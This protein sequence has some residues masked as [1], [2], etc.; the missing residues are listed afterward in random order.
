[1]RIRGAIERSIF[2][3]GRISFPTHYIPPPRGTYLFLRTKWRAAA[4]VSARGS[5]RFFAI[6]AAGFASMA[7]LEIPSPAISVAPIRNLNGYAGPLWD[8]AWHRGCFTLSMDKRV[9]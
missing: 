9:R 6:E 7:P 3:S 2:A 8:S 1:M 4:D 5:L